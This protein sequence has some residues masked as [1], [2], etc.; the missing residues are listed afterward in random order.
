MTTRIA[1]YAASANWTYVVIVLATLWFGFQIIF[2]MA[3]QIW[4]SLSPDPTVVDAFFYG[5]TP[6]AVGW[7]LAIFGVYSAILLTLMRALH[8]VGL[9][10]LLGAAGPALREFI[11]VSIY[12]LPIYAFLTV[13]SL[14]LPEVEQQFSI[15]EWLPVLFA[16]LPLLFIQI[17]A[18]EFVFRGYLQSHL[19]ALTRN[20]IIW[21]GLPSILF[22][23]IHYDPLSPAYSRWAY[24]FWAA[25]LGVVC[26]D[27]TARSGTLGPALAVHFINNIGA[28]LILAADDWLYGAA[29]FVWPTYGEAWVPWVPFEALF[30]FTIWMAARLALR[31]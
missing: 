18:E 2:G 4:S 20:P 27:L 31:R 10:T 17:S 25:G 13:P 30:L 22:G 12:L 9:S 29:L 8:S 3:F 7:N 24:I 21:I 1:P 19:A 26:A 16:I 28:I 11:R 6:T 5:H 14:F 23:L 15:A